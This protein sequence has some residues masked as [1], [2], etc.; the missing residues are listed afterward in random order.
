MTRFVSQGARPWLG[1][2]GTALLFMT[3]SA[4]ADMAPRVLHVFSNEGGREPHSPPIYLNTRESRT[5]VGVV[6]SSTDT[7][8]HYY[9]LDFAEGVPRFSSSLLAEG[10]AIGLYT[11]LVEV[12]TGDVIFGTNP[13]ALPQ[14]PAEP[15]V[16]RWTFAE[17]PVNAVATPTDPGDDSG[18]FGSSFKPRG[19]F[20]LDTDDNVYFGGGGGRNGNGLFRLAADG[21]LV[22]LV[23]F[24]NYAEGSGNST[25]YKKGQYPVALLVDEANRTLYGINVRDQ[26]AGAGDP[27]GLPD[28]D[29]SAGTL[30][31]IDL[32]DVATDGTT[33]V[34][35]LHTFAK[36]A[37]GE[38]KGN[39]SGQQALV[40]V[41]DWLYGTTTTALW[42]FKPGTP[43]S[44]A[45]V[46]T[47]AE[48]Q[49]DGIT[50]W[51]PLVLAADGH[52]YGTARRTVTAEGEPSGAGVLFRVMIGQSDN[53]SDD[54]YEIL[55]R[56]DVETDG[57]F[58]VG[59]TAGPVVERMQTL[60]GATKRGGNS[61]DALKTSDADGYGTLFA[62][63]IELPVTAD[64]Q[65]GADPQTITLGEST[66]LTWSV[67]N[68]D[69]CAGDGDWGGNKVSEG[70]ES[71]TPPLD[72]EFNYIL[73]CTDGGG[74]RV[75]ASVTVTVE[76]VD[77]GGNG[78][79]SSGG[80][81]T[82][83]LLWLSALGFLAAR[84]R[85][86]LNP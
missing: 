43:G 79:G 21:T 63:D 64:I 42:R 12:S 45:L 2:L 25:V 38:I 32:S 54:E 16:F 57:A 5:L 49:D 8:G 22:R 76:P 75:E 80:G 37:E 11:G 4:M 40:Q 31:S 72:G 59:L 84:R 85:R 10:G 78:G 62:V 60:Y 55:H 73:A 7:V 6:P 9:T 29:E 39:D 65:L 36:E 30:F 34:T 67:S 1:S 61:G 69:N 56:F 51:G 41:G 18:G 82:L 58:P 47:F 23:E 77:N 3:S 86:A 20:S 19:L 48:E 15:T 68:A 44:F 35:V 13:F 26:S 66:T 70:S 50:P 83:S 52:V 14:F 71:L 24:E 33:P 27:E 46:H 81:G 74:E 53:H 17:A 28:G